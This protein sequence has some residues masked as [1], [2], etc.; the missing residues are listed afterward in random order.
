MSGRADYKV[1][2]HVCMFELFPEWGSREMWRPLAYD[3]LSFR[4]HQ[5]S[6]RLFMLYEWMD[7]RNPGGQQCFIIR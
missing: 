5:T 2:P 6:V 1:N 3:S 4:N 7:G